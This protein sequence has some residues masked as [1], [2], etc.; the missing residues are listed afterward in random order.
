MVYDQAKAAAGKTGNDALSYLDADTTQWEGE[1]KVPPMLDQCEYLEEYGGHR[2]PTSTFDSIGP[3]LTGSFQVTL[4]DSSTH[5]V[6]P[7]W[8]YLLDSVKECTCEWAANI[9]GVNAELIRE[10]CLAWATRPEGQRWGNGG[11]HFQLATDQ[12]GD[13]VQRI[14]TLLHL[15]HLTGNVDT[16]AGNRGPTRAPSLGAEGAGPLGPYWEVTDMTNGCPITT[17]E[18]RRNAPCPITR[19]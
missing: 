12:V 17:S 7:V 14:R 2:P 10:A 1:N 8:S 4:K 16:P 19:S 3:A 13:V 15:C 9:T 11:I 18:R 5:T 6:R